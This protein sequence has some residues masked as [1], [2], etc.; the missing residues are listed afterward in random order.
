LRRER[1]QQM[2]LA[3][4]RQLSRVDIGTHAGR[5]SRLT[6]PDQVASV[7]CASDIGP[8]RLAGGVQVRQNAYAPILVTGGRS[9][10]FA[11]SLRASRVVAIGVGPS[12]KAAAERRVLGWVSQATFSTPSM[13]MLGWPFVGPR[14]NAR[15]PVL[16]LIRLDRRVAVHYH[17]G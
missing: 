8:I 9:L 5:P 16:C 2:R 14:P 10:R 12:D 3:G 6:G 1:P 15:G 7:Y 17:I 11:G 13:R 4:L